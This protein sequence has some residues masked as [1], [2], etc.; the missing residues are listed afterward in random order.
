MTAPASSSHVRLTAAATRTL[1]RWILLAI[2]V[3][4]GLSGL[5]GRDPWK[6]DDAAGFGVMWSIAQ[7]GFDDWLMP[8][9]AGRP[10]IA[11]GPLAFWL[12]AGFIKLFG[13]L[14]GPVNAAH[15]LTAAS[16]FATCAFVWY[17]T[18]LLGRRAEVQPFAYVFGGQPESQ[19]YGRT[20]ADG[21]ILLLLA[22]LGLAQRGHESTAEVVQ[23]ACVA[24]LLYG[25]IR[26][27]DMPRQGALWAGLGLGALA[28][29]GGLTLPLMLMLTIAAATWWCPPLK[30][31]PLLTF[32][33]P[34]AVALAALWPL[35]LWLNNSPP[36]LET[37]QHLRDWL[38]YD[39]R[40][41]RGPSWIALGFT[42]KN[43]PL[44][45]WPLWPLA[46]WS[47]M[48]WKGLRRQAHIGLPLL[49]STTVL[50]M[51]L[52]HREASDVSFML[53]IP[54]L[55]VLGA[56]GLPTLKRGAI[57]AIDW[58]ALLFFTLL[59][60]F[61]WVVWLAKMTGF[62]AQTARNLFRLVP[63]FKPEFN[64]FALCFA[65]A[66]TAAWFLIVRW[67][68]SR[69]PHVIWRSVVI[70]AAGTTLM[71]VLMMTL[72][73]PTINYAK[74]YRD[75]AQQVA[76][77]L[78]ADYKC[79]QP[80]RVGDAQLASFAWFG[81][82]RFGNSEDECDV[83]LRYDPH[84]YGAPFSLSNMQWKLVWE[85]HRPADRD[86]RFRLYQLQEKPANKRS[87]A[88]KRRLG[89]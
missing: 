39:R 46:I 37:L 64:G 27:L 50:L 2:C 28:L 31:R 18:Y 81:E 53:L 68:L 54:P 36:E 19:D 49:L 44:F 14:I 89:R 30:L 5:F 29:S 3:I 84:D 35:L 8:N 16:F 45:A 88:A 76:Q 38:R 15:L 47:W 21:A 65:L 42:L 12:G 48:S 24:M 33:L 4:Y 83:M 23:L 17:G 63:G 34:L 71:W 82:L 51:L 66:V 79:I 60:G 75:V 10:F 57:N 74:T 62:P 86:E 78:P 41:H 77:A 20:L 43:L 58:F 40:M 25:L 72:W 22:C 56:F 52:L 7:G 6:N 26:S 67:R 73:L 9:I 61:V 85:G 69:A 87:L 13:W 59:G 11:A 80:V 1:P 70:S 55:A 32:A